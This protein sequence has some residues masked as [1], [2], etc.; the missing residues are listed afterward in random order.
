MVEADFDEFVAVLDTVCS[1]GSKPMSASAKA[2]FF[3][4]LEPYPLSAVRV[5]FFAHLKDP[6]RGSFNPRPAD[7]IAKICPPADVDALLDEAVTQLNRRRYGGDDVW[8]DPVVYW[9]AQRVG[10][11]TMLNLGRELLVKR[12]G[13]ALEALRR[14]GNVPPV[15]PA[16][17]ALP[18]PGKAVT[19]KATGRAHL[20]TILA[21]CKGRSERSLSRAREA[22][23]PVADRPDAVAKLLPDSVLAYARGAEKG[24]QRSPRG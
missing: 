22:L 23:L 11:H 3:K 16:M 13:A 7:I 24:A 6:V 12:F 14:E 18:A 15:P 1:Y 8:S 2:V 20:A 5:A 21:G 17:A 10:A 19:D 4:A 9:A